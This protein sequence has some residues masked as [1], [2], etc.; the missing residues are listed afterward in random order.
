[1][2]V[3]NIIGNVNTKKIML[4]NA[5]EQKNGTAYILLGEENVGK[6]FAA[7]QFAKALNCL[8][9]SV[10]MDCC[11][12]CVNCRLIDKTL[13]ELDEHDCQINPHPDLVY[14]NTEKA[15]LSKEVVQ[16]AIENLNIYKAI[17]LKRKVV[18]IQDADRMNKSAA[19][20]ILKVLEEPHKD[21]VII[22]IVNNIDS[23][24]PTIVS[25]C[26]R[27]ELQRASISEIEKATGRIMMAWTEIE[28]KEAAS[29]SDGKIGD[30]LRYIEVKQQFKD[31]A[32]I[33]SAV[34][35]RKDDVESIFDAI[36]R[37]EEL[38]REEKEKEKK[39]KKKG[40]ARLF[41][42]DIIKILSYIYRDYMLEK[43]GIKSIL[44]NRYGISTT[45][46]RDY[47]PA[48]ISAILKIIER[49]CRDVESNANVSVLFTNLLFQIRKEGLSA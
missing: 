37:V 7:R 22:L 34:S 26:R 8:R 33:F 13:G 12:I 46:I 49:S 1:M 32:A 5:S 10:D 47:T 21:L 27:I 36:K 41:L 14:I 43:L 16:V 44:R 38:H 19:N 30:A 9:P 39:A 3:N 42:L 35:G 17:Q 40:I 6:N 48:K 45:D 25:R 24:M 23:Q 31:A 11:D 15:Q 20:S 18:I 29:F 2:S 28:V 4:S